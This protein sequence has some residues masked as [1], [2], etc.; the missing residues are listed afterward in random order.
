MLEII[1]CIVIINTLRFLLSVCVSVT[2]VGMAVTGL[3]F[4][5]KIITCVS[6]LTFAELEMATSR[7]I[8]N[9]CKAAAAAGLTLCVAGYAKDAIVG[10]YHHTSDGQEHKIIGRARLERDTIFHLPVTACREQG[11]H[12][13][14]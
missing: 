14:D 13:H 2:D 10:A 11:S 3:R 4:V 8:K 1:D 12:C 6:A 9:C 7:D 5:C